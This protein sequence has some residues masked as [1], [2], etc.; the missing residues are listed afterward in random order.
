[1]SLDKSFSLS[2]TLAYYKRIGSPIV[3]MATAIG[4]PIAI[5]RISGSN[6]SFLEALVGRLPKPGSFEY[7]TIKDRGGNVLDHGLV[8]FFQSPHSFTGEDVVEIQTHGVPSVIEAIV[9]QIKLLGAEQAL[10]GEFSFRA[11]H[12]GKM[13]LAEAEGLQTSLSTEGLGQSAASKLLEIS[14]HSEREVLASLEEA[15]KSLELARARVEAAID[16]SEAEEEQAGDVAHAKD[17]IEFVKQ[18]LSALISAFENFSRASVEPRIA[19]IGEPNVGKSTLLNRVLGGQRALVSP[20]AGT[21]RDIVEGRLLLSGLSGGR[22]VRLIDTAGIREV[23]GLT[24]RPSQESLEKLGIE[25]GLESARGAHALIWIRKLSSKNDPVSEEIQKL[26]TSKETINIF[27][28]AEDHANEEQCFFDLRSE[29]LDLKKVIAEKIESALLKVLSQRAESENELLISRRQY[30]HILRS[31]DSVARA[32]QCLGT[33]N[34]PTAPIELCG[35]FLREAEQELK[36]SIGREV[37][38]A[39][40]EAIFR[41]FCLGK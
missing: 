10:P 17:R 22:W 16:F 4:G 35:E 2:N 11:V 8:L 9:T 13:T 27:S 36:F 19:I 31:L 7:R 30:Q 21:T 1:M 37:G 33:S 24:N 20:L 26:V 39:Y 18:K 23:I 29:S 38:E 5:L 15:I 34:Q 41:D 40:I 3:A 6:L 28:F 12:F 14:A 32:E 25:Y